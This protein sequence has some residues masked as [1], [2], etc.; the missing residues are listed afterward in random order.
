LI[1]AFIDECRHAGHAVESICRVLS[2]QGCQIAARTYRSWASSGQR[3]AD[4]TVSD[5]IVEDAVRD[6]AW[7]ID[8]HGPMAGVRRLTPKGSTGGAR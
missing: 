6:A 4:R 2:E 8:E 3:V 1:V 5:A 7:T